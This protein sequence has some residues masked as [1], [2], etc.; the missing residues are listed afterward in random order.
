MS[1]HELLN[2]NQR[3]HFEVLFSML[4][5]ELVRIERLATEPLAPA[6]TLTIVDDDLPSQFADRA[7]PLLAETRRLLSDLSAELR[8]SPRHLSRRRSIHAA[9]TAA[10]IRIDDSSPTELR[11]YGPVDPR[12][13]TEVGPALNAIRDAIVAVASLLEPATRRA[14][15]RKEKP[16]T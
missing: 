2:P 10:V 7:R 16:W 5:E 8:L 13:V 12:F 9:L 14:V 3:R 15:S 11:G 6:R 1:K 4:E